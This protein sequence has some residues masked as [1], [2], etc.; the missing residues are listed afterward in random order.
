[1]QT[2]N[3]YTFVWRRELPTNKHTILYNKINHNIDAYS[4]DGMSQTLAHCY[5]DLL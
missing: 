5:K 4:I 3:K 1:M 2:N